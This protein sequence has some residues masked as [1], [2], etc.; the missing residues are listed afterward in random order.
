MTPADAEV[1]RLATENAKLKKINAALMSRVERA[2]DQPNNA[3]GLFE[4]AITLDKTV[5]RR[6]AELQTALRSVEGANEALMKAKQA[7]EKANAFKS[8]FL[9]FVS[10][11]LLQPLNAARLNLSTLNEAAPN[12]EVRRFSHQIDLAL[13]SLEDLIRT[14]LDMSKLDAGAMRPD[15]ACVPLEQVLSPL[16]LEFAPLAAARGLKLTVRPSRAWVRTDPM[17][18]RRVLQNLINNALRYTRR[19]GVLLGARA[20]GDLIRIDVSDTGPGIAPDRREAIFEEFQREGGPGDGGFGLG[21]SIV[22]RL[23]QAL[24][25]RVELTS[26][27]GFGST[28]SLLLPAAS[29]VEAAPAPE[30]VNFAPRLGGVHGAEILVIEN[31]PSVASAMQALLERWGCRVSLANSPDEARE[32]LRRGAASPDLVIADYHLDDGAR[33]FDAI[34]VVQKEVEMAIPA[35]IVTADHSEAVTEAAAARGL[36]ILRKPVKPAELRSLIAY[37]LA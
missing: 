9:A 24:E 28:F 15:I 36:E 21:L 33:G 5:R 4:V 6:T 27:V 23:S 17:L 31:E 18:L 13:T 34:D 8:T 3:F 12:A 30:A 10:H 29:A 19:G 37:L 2:M 11:D 7:A 1:A 20:R 22:R 35:C 14:L 25:H 26:R 32:A 16:R